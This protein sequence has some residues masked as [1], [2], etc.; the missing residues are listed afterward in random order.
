MIPYSEEWLRLPAAYAAIVARALGD[1][2]AT[3]WD[4]PFDP[5]DATICLTDGTALVWDEE[6]G[7]RHGGFVSGRKGERTVLSGMCYLGGG[8]LPEPA[9]VVE[10]LALLREGGN[11]DAADRPTYRSFRDYDDGFDALLAHYA[12]GLVTA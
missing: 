12:E 10:S 4:D 5:R 6:T 2:A 3:W 1:E 7:W 8:V 9:R 11:A